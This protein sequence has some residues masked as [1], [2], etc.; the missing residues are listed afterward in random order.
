MDRCLSGPS[1]RL[2]STGGGYPR[3]F[4]S[5]TQKMARELPVRDPRLAGDVLADGGLTRVRYEVGVP[6]AAAHAISPSDQAIRHRRSLELLEGA[7]VVPDK[8]WT[9]QER[10][11]RRNVMPTPSVPHGN[12][13]MLRSRYEAQDPT[14]DC[15]WCP[16]CG[17]NAGHRIWRLLVH[18]AWRRQGS[19]R[20]SSH[21]GRPLELARSLCSSGHR[22]FAPIDKA[23][24]LG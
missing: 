20:Y 13:R 18:G 22:L 24:P 10:S 5:L 19:T 16:Y 15:P 7:R 11:S 3:G 8:V 23:T 17:G 2:A 21:C 6:N 14:S 1:S 12:G 4:H 9:E